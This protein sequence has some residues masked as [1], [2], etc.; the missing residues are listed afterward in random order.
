MTLALSATESRLMPCKDYVFTAEV[1]PTQPARL[2]LKGSHQMSNKGSGLLYA[3]PGVTDQRQC[4]PE[5]SLFYGPARHMSSSTDNINSKHPTA[6]LSPE[7]DVASC[8]TSNLNQSS[9]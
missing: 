3:S 4:L 7:C 9:F 2:T 6:I 1:S 5:T 8:G